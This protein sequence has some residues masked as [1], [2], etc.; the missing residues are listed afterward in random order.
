MPA[1]HSTWENN[2]EGDCQGRMQP[3]DT[4]LL[5]T[6]LNSPFLCPS[7]SL[8]EPKSRPGQGV[9][10]VLWE[11]CIYLR[12]CICGETVFVLGKYWFSSS[13]FSLCF[14]E[15]SPTAGFICLGLNSAVLELP[16][17]SLTINELVGKRKRIWSCIFAWW[18]FSRLYFL[19]NK[20][21]IYDIFLFPINH[22]LHSM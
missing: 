18:C 20:I 8:Q 6:L 14:C 12:T 21:S 7:A 19:W 2:G 17:L 11:Y 9:S 13:P 1:R 10:C 15:C 5:N 22:H 16:I 4:L 3:F